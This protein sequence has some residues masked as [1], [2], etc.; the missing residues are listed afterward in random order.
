M[1]THV[2]VLLYLA[3]LLF[4]REMLQIKAVEK[5]KADILCSVMFFRKSC[6]LCDNGAQALCLL[7]NLG[8]RHTLR[9]RNT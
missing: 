7:D 8:R 6:R 2:H 3:L 4:E 1:T 9:I 5:I